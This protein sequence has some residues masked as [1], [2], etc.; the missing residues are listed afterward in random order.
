MVHPR[1]PPRSIG[2]NSHPRIVRTATALGHHPIDVLVRVLDIAGL[3]VHAVLSVDDEARL[4]AL[5]DPLVDAGRAVAARRPRV[6]I[7]LGELLH[8][9]V[10]DLEMNGLVLLVVCSR[11]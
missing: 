2:A 5:L 4:S 9:H 6:D 11:E 10:G 8:G 1:Y 3:A 7:V